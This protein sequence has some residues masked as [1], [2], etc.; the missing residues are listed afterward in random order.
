MITPPLVIVST[1]HILEIVNRFLEIRTTTPY[2]CVLTLGQTLLAQWSS[3]PR[4]HQTPGKDAGAGRIRRVS[5]PC[6]Q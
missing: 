2:G 1:Y 6:Q 5:D 4:P 3:V